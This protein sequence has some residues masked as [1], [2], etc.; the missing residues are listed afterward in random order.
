MAEKIPINS[1]I[2]NSRL[3]NK[4][5]E[6]SVKTNSTGKIKTMKIR[7]QSSTIKLTSSIQN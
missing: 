4:P 7:I 5:S 6:L 2:I 1:K 3:I